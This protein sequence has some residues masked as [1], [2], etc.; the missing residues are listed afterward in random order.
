MH[1]FGAFDKNKFFGY[2][3]KCV[4]RDF[5]LIHA[6]LLLLFVNFSAVKLSFVVRY[7]TL[8]CFLKLRFYT[9]LIGSAYN[10]KYSVDK[11]KSITKL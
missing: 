6:F 9:I 3:R 1:A 11:T 10:K 7:L 8:E 5:P 2:Y 4:L